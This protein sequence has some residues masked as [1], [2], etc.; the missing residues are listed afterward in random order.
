MTSSSSSSHSYPSYAE[1]VLLA[2]TV[3]TGLVDAVSYLALGR[4]FTAN[5]TGN[6]VLLG[7][8]AAG[9]QEL[10][11]SRSGAALGAFLLGAVVG[12]RMSRPIRLGVWHRWTSF[13]FG[14]EGALFLAA[15]AVAIGQPIGFPDAPRVYTIIVLTG[16]A[17]GMRNATV[18]SL[19]VPDH[20]TTVLT[21][22]LARLAADSR[23][24]GGDSQRWVSRASSV[25]TMLAGAAL[26]AWFLRYS[27]ML[28][29]AICTLVSALCA[30]TVYVGVRG[31]EEQALASQSPSA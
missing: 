25:V 24:A 3:V 29:L 9:V 14:V 7:F 2:L 10:S 20:T 1:P 5:M 11:V 15:M 19:A 28:P 31:S 8:A 26:G 12:G 22:T 23:L 13:A 6:V 17:M 30:V 21:L 18:R 27:V 4:V 16:I